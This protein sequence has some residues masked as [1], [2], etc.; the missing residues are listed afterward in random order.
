M[1]LPPAAPAER[2]AT[3]PPKKETVEIVRVV[4]SGTF[5]VV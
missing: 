5:G 2:G 3:K 4:G 1:P